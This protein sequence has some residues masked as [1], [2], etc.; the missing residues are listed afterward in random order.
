MLIAVNTL[1]AGG[2]F[3]LVAVDRYQMEELAERGSRRARPVL[4]ALRTLSFQLSGAQLGITV[5]SLVLGFVVD[6][7]LAPVLRP[8][9]GWLPGVDSGSIAAI[10]AGL[11]LGLA[12]ILQMIFGEL[13]PK[14]LAIA[15]PR[16]SAMLFAPPIVLF[17][18]VFGPLIRALNA[19]ANWTMQ[20]LGIEPREELEGVRS[21]HELRGTLRWAAR[22][23]ALH[24]VEPELLDRA[25]SLREKTARDVLVP[26]PSVAALPAD[27]TLSDLAQS[28]RTSGFSRFPIYT[29]TGDD[30]QGIAHVK[31]VFGVPAPARASTPAAATMQPPLV[32]P[33]A[34]DLQSLL[35]DMQAKQLP[36]AV[37]VDEFGSPAGIVT[38]EDVVEELLGEIEDE[39]DRPRTLAVQA[40]ERTFTVEGLIRREELRDATGFELPKGRIETLAGL[41]LALFQRIPQAGDRVTYGRWSFQVEAMD[42]NRIARVQVTAPPESRV[43]E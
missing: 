19:A 32:V 23:G 41:L 26:R 29:P 5:S 2:Q 39:H 20:R 42:G 37:V 14:N 33:M 28:A 31:D 7:A 25:L 15:R 21:V 17:N 24:G 40:G 34:R 27:A 16:A 10:A 36:M 6:A 43:S 4:R 22:E 3:A 18:S 35:V 13:A 38:S 12:T 11:A 9:I 30:V 1:F 8:L